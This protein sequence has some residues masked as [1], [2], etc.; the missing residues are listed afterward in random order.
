MP[1]FV[2]ALMELTVPSVP[3]LD[4]RPSLLP[5]LDEKPKLPLELDEKPKPLPELEV[6]KPSG[7]LPLELPKP[8][9]LLN[10]L[11]P[12]ELP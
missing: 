4:E 1:L 5:E 10:R 7:P 6:V 9:E 8:D 11:D 3:E 12:L 2:T